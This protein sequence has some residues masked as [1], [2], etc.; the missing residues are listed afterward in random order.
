MTASGE[1]GADQGAALLRQ[2]LAVAEETLRAL[3]AGE[4][5]AIVMDARQGEQR[6]F[7]LETKDRPYRRLV[8]RMSEGAALVDADGL[9]VYANQ[10]LA[11]LLGVPLERL[12]GSLFPDWL[13]ESERAQL[14]GRLATASSGGHHEHMLR[15]GDGASVPVLV[16]I[17]DTAEPEGSLRC[18][19]V[20]DLSRQKAQQQQLDHLNSTLTD[21]LAE[22]R[23]ANDDLEA[24]RVR[25]EEANS[26]LKEVN[27]QLQ[28][29]NSE[30]EQVNDSVRGFTAVAAHDLRS[31]LVS[32]IGFSTIL[33]GKWAEVSED[34]RR[35]FV[36]A[37]DRQSHKMSG[38]I[39]DLLTVARIEGGALDTRPEPVLVGE[40]ISQCLETTGD[41]TAGVSVSCSPDLVVR[42]DPQHVG[43][44]IDNY[45]QNA[46]KYGEPPVRIEAVR[47]G[48][49][50]DIRVSDHGPG[51]PQEFVSRLFGK[52]ARAQ[53]PGTKAKRGTGLGLSIVRGLAEANG[54]RARY[55]PADSG[56]S[57]FIVELP[58]GDPEPG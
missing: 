27:A 34:D 36:A 47:R 9:V 7:T 57:C 48:D 1:P 26:K 25:V 49:L 39:D 58:A 44:I 21:R 30:L 12:Q 3:R 42:A 5:D 41:D 51:V 15:Q 18:V 40:A 38:L 13:D 43:R 28:A 8:E 46:L 10:T 56:G 2:R 50:V 11:T 52:F 6:I 24:E 53:T 33:T 45:L 37:I 54:G 20:T 16:G 14:L 55:E 17:S 29:V 23:R 32:I 19:T 4:A 35:K 31:P 22:L